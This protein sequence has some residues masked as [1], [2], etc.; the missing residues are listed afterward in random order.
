MSVVIAPPV[1]QSSLLQRLF[2]AEPRTVVHETS[3]TTIVNQPGGGF[4]FRTALRN[5]GIGAALAGALG[6]AS[7]LAKV[8]LPLVGKVASL[9]GLARL[10]GVGGALGAATAAI[11]L[12]V[13]LVQ[14]S[15]AAKAAVVGAGVGAAAGAVLP[16]VPIWLGAAAGAGIGW[17]IH[18]ARNRTSQ[19]DSYP[20]YPGYAAYPGFAP[21]GT[22]PGGRVPA[23]MVAVSPAYGG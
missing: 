22:T 17:A 15:P 7:L 2:G 1:Q 3:T 10:I 5:G 8:A 9:G 13:P 14:R 20:T 12:L 11:P 6:G 16:F 19:G 21:Y 18:A 4:S 23:G